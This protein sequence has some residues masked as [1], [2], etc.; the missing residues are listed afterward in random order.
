MAEEIPEVSTAP[1]Y[2]EGKTVVRKCL[3]TAG[4]L[5]D[6]WRLTARTLG[7]NPAET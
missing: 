1:Y 7:D 6:R 4:I 3:N 5:L 2:D